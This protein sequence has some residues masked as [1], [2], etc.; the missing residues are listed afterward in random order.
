MFAVGLE[1]GE[2]GCGGAEIGGGAGSGGTSVNYH[3]GFQ[4]MGKG[5][6]LIIRGKAV[7]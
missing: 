5:V 2:V 7:Y 1:E 4:L 6:E 3:L